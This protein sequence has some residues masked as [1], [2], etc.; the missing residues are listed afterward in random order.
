[1]VEISV[2]TFAV[3]SHWADRAVSAVLQK[4]YF[5][6][7]TDKALD[8]GHLRTLGARVWCWRLWRPWDMKEV[9]FLMLM[10]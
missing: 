2:R 10:N 9:Q 4:G 6:I 3:L 7:G 1:M 5:D 8:T